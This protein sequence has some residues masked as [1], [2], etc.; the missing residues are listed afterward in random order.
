MK[1]LSATALLTLGVAAGG[2]A[3]SLFATTPAP[4]QA[5]QQD[6]ADMMERM[7]A[8]TQP[9]EEHAYLERMLGEWDVELSLIMGGQKLPPSKGTAKTEWLFDGRWLQTTMKGSMMGRPIESVN[10]LGYDKFKMSYVTTSVSTMDTAM[11]EAEGDLDTRQNDDPWDDALILW[12]TLDEYLTGE[13]DKMVKTVIRFTGP[14]ERVMEIH[15]MPIGETG[16]Q[17]IEMRFKRQQ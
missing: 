10:L 17:V 2:L 15:D 14:D 6:M 8:F 12:G 5:D 1:L 16:T 7:A 11:N 9:G 4:A 13:H 3:P